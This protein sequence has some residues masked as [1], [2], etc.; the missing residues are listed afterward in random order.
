MFISFNI[1]N[2]IKKYTSL[3]QNTCIKHK[4][5]ILFINIT[6]VHHDPFLFKAPHGV[7]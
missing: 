2:E 6:L 7:L 3:L 4:G 1:Y 5:L